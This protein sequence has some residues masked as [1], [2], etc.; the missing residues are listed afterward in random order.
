MPAILL[1]NSKYQMHPLCFH[2]FDLTLAHNIYGPH[3][4]LLSARV[5]LPCSLKKDSLGPYLMQGLRDS[6]L[7]LQKLSLGPRGEG[8]GKGMGTTEKPSGDMCPRVREAG[9]SSWDPP[10]RAGRKKAVLAVT[11]H[12]LWVK[13]P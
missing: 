1:E 12:H 6:V 5:T 2:W 4:C 9:C 13:A 10:R 7:A 3:S 11:Q 8:E